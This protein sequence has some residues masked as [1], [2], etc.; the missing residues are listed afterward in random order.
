[1]APLIGQLVAQEIATGQ[2]SAML[3]SYRIERFGM[4][5]VPPA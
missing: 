1:L 3:T 2:E 4:L 5:A